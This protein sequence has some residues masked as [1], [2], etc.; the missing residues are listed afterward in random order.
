M[1]D[2]LYAASAD[3]VA[4][5]S[6]AR[7]TVLQIATPSGIQISIIAIDITFDGTNASATPVLVTL[8]RQASAGTGG[9][10]L[11]ANWGP[12]PLDPNDPATTVTALK[13]AWATTEPV[14]TTVYKSWRISPTGGLT[15]PFPL[16]QE[17]V[18]PASSWIALVVNAGATV[19][20]TATLTWKQ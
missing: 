15:Y 18:L 1:A 12:N 8:E 16:G 6:G 20:A 7:H 3:Q 11:T 5:A 17:P 10:A 13:G 4:V 19:N 9:V 14:L 2:F